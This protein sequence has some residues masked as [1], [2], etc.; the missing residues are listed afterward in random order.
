MEEIANALKQLEDRK[1]RLLAR[2]VLDAARDPSSPLHGCF[3]W[4]DGRAAEAYRLEQARELIRSI[5]ADVTTQEG[6][7]RVVRYVQASNPKP[8]GYQSV[9][10]LRGGAQARAMMRTELMR[11]RGNLARTLGLAQ[12]KEPDLPNGTVGMIRDAAI[13]IRGALDLCAE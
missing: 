1:G 12:A 11:I 2:D 6:A 13:A 4:D 3:E 8:E 7:V 10:K 5:Q 9:P